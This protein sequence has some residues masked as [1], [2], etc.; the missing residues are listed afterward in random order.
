MRRHIQQLGVVLKHVIV[1]VVVIAAVDSQRCNHGQA[2]ELQLRIFAS[3]QSFKTF[4]SARSNMASPSRALKTTQLSATN[5]GMTVAV[6]KTLAELN[7]ERSV[8]TSVL[9]LFGLDW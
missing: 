3:F 7:T 1:V 9:R 2:H 6:F 5:T 4:F 8:S